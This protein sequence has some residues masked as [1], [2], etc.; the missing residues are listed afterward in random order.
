MCLKSLI[1]RY[2]IIMLSISQT[3]FIIYPPGNHF[4]RFFLV[5]PNVFQRL[6][7]TR[8]AS[9]TSLEKTAL[10]VIS[11]L[12]FSISFWVWFWFLW[13]RFRMIGRLW[14]PWPPW[15]IACGRAAATGSRRSLHPQTASRPTDIRGKASRVIP[16]DRDNSK[17]DELITIIRQKRHLDLRSTFQPILNL[18]KTILY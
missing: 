6:H 9:K 18:Q 7:I 5:L 16:L 14:R 13:F 17:N 8:F 11:T 4:K 2:L 12:D 3:K 10:Q 1:R 15:P